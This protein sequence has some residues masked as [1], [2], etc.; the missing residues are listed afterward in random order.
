MN[1]MYRFLI[2][3]KYKDHVEVESM[4]SVYRVYSQNK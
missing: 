3:K 1:N 4:W 2:I